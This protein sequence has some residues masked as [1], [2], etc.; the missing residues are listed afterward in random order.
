MNESGEKEL[1]K[2]LGTTKTKKPQV[3]I[4]T[5]T[6]REI[7]ISPEHRMLTQRGYV[8]ANELTTEDDLRT[9]NSI[10]NGNTKIQEDELIFTTCMIFDGYCKKGRANYTDTQGKIYQ[11]FLKACDSLGIEYKIYPKKGSKAMTVSLKMGKDYRYVKLL[12]KYGLLDKNSHN[13]RLP[14]VFFDLSYEQ[15]MEFIGIMLSTD[16]YLCRKGSN[17]GIALANEELIDDIQTILSMVGIP[18]RKTYKKNNCYGAWVLS[19]N[20]EHLQHIYNDCELYDNKE[21]AKQIIEANPNCYDILL[22]YPKH[23]K[24][25][26][27]VDYK[28]FPKGISMR[29]R[30]LQCKFDKLAST[31]PEIEKYRIKDFIYDQIKEIEYI[32]EEVEMYDLEVEK[33][34]NF[35][36][37]GFVSH[38][39]RLLKYAEA[40]SFGINNTGSILAICSNDFLIRSMSR[41]VIDI[42]Q[43]QEFGEVFPSMS[44][45]KNSKIF[46]KETDKEWRLSTC[47]LV[48]SYMAISR[49]S[50][51]VGL[52]ASTFISLDDMYTDFNEALDN[53][54]NKRLWNKYIT[55]FRERFVKGRPVKMAIVGTKWSAFDL[56]SQIEEDLHAHK[57]FVP[58]PKYSYT[59]ISTDGTSAIIKVPAL[60]ENGQTTCPKLISTEEL[61]EKK[62][63]IP[64]YLWL[65]NYQQESIPP[66]GLEFDYNLLKTYPSKMSV[67]DVSFATLDPARKGKNYVS[68]PIFIKVKT[69]DDMYKYALVDAMFKKKAMTDLYDE[70]VM[71]VKKNKIIKLII[72]NNTD[73]SLPYVIEQKLKEANVTTC[74]VVPIYSYQNKEQRIKD[75]QGIMK[76][77]IIFPEKSLYPISTD[78]GQLME[79]LTSYSFTYPNRFD[80]G[81]DSVIMF[82]MYQIADVGKSTKAIAIDRRALG[83]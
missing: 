50:N 48:N 29:K 69:E 66:E 34:H 56:L 37:N 72:E 80:D 9:L 64:S 13:K 22:S 12:E 25:G 70:I 74:E 35:I 41:S 33:Y 2:V 23:I 30:T 38:N 7:F 39:S 78:L 27:K 53:E 71:K 4:K 19:I 45:A 43:S 18:S 1:C 42:L 61:L 63:K 14:K 46:T 65:C 54:L 51:A 44:Y 59:W 6:G 21:I 76:Q 62:S 81:I 79:Q 24:K 8:A 11:R 52:R 28:A 67:A 75:Y 55:V 5:A 10:L 16:G 77:N 3:R 47:A 83:I 17:H 15:K 73:T 32:S 40:W 57:E 68:M 60:D 49:D 58:D 20:G 31:Y 26:I 82:T 36:A